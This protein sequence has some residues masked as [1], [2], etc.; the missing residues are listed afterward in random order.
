MKILKLVS[1]MFCTLLIRS[2][3]VA[4]TFTFGMFMDVHYAAI[5]DNGTRKYSQSLEKINH[6]TCN[7]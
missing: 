6:V 5:P 4:Q 2:N 7:L 3:V 1:L